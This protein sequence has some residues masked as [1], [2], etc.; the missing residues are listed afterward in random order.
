[1]S[2]LSGPKITPRGMLHRDGIIAKPSHTVRD[3]PSKSTFSRPS[4][5]NALARARS[6]PI[7]TEPVLAKRLSSRKSVLGATERYSDAGLLRS[8]RSNTGAR[9]IISRALSS[10]PTV[11]GGAGEKHSEASVSQSGPKRISLSRPS[12]GRRS[13][14]VASMVRDSAGRLNIKQYPKSFSHV[15]SEK[16]PCA[17]V[18]RHGRQ[19][20]APAAAVNQSSL[21]GLHHRL[22]E[23]ASLE[24]ARERSSGD[25]TSFTSQNSFEARTDNLVAQASAMATSYVAHLF[26]CFVCH[27]TSRIGRRS[28]S[29]ASFSTVV[30]A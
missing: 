5:S 3:L 30:E 7:P 17:R 21:V 22:K 20:S 26:H 11:A 15:N 1:M 2:S 12:S 19:A 9:P 10:T 25:R 8:G 29:Y 24:N 28:E 27:R 13:A 16:V 6:R 18:I 4:I 23:Y 14:A